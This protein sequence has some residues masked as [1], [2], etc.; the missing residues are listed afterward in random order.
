MI[1]SFDALVLAHTKLRVHKIRTGMAIGIA[2]LLFGLMG[3]VIIIVQG[4]FVSVD[5]FSDE[6]LN[7]RT[8]L[9]LSHSGQDMPFNEFM[10]RDDPEFVVEV[11]AAH[12]EYVD[13][14]RVA[15]QK[16][17]ITYN[18]AVEDPSPVGVDPDTKKK[19]VREDD[20]RSDVVQSVANKR[21]LAEYKPF[22]INGFL[23]KY[24]SATI[25]QE[26]DQVAP[27]NGTLAYMKDGKESLKADAQSFYG[28]SEDAPSLNILEQSITEPFISDTDFDPSKGEIP[29]IVPYSN[30]EKLLGLKKLDASAT[31]QQKYDRL[32]EVRSRINEVTTSYC[33][34]N[35]ASQALLS[36]ALGQQEEIKRN[37]SEPGY[38]KPALI[39]TVPSETSCGAITVQSDTRTAAEKRY[40]EQLV[41]YEKE[42]GTYLGEPQQ[43]LVKV[44]G[45]GI[46]SDMITS[47][48]WSMAELTKTLFASSLGYSTWAI[49]EHLL[50]E[51]PEIARPDAIFKKTTDTEVNPRLLYGSGQYLVEFSNKDEA[52]QLLGGLGS[53]QTGNVY[54]YPFGSGVLIVDEFKHLFTQVLMWTFAI[55]GGV[56]VIIL[57][58][59]V[60]RTVAD[61]RRESSIFRAIGASR[62]D[63]A[64]VY[65]M[66]VLLLALR[67]VIFSA[68]LA[69]AIGLTIEIMFWQ[70][71]TLGARLSYAASDVTKEFHLFSLTSPYLLWIIGT[72]LAAS[73]V[74]SIIPILLGARRNPI[75]DMRNE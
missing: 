17:G 49:P 36:R 62:L 74:A 59:I 35:T 14:K 13:K 16:Y 8:I 33:Y 72:I 63:I 75:K 68:I 3:A 58:G 4:I 54:V 2:G 56:A 69:I 25:I 19:T 12:K 27:D 26:Y 46:S 60:G 67:I 32:Q 73:I 23:K 39:Y 6:G 9:A 48:Q 51:L 64:S 18:P 22:D 43:Q 21:R 65:G 40:D 66:F 30:A 34:R 41:L 20:L 52:R 7:S 71:A 5:N 37:D 44:R 24:P 55:I 29:V 42:L 15:A 57:A 1:R 53:M 11:E 61:G 47:G 45:V 31:M 38:V 28:Y 50:N 70:D 10:M